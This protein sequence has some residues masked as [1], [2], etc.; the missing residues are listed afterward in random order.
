MNLNLLE[1]LQRLF[2]I[3]E[4]LDEA[5]REIERER[6][7]RQR[8]VDA[9]VSRLERLDAHVSEL[10]ERLARLEAARD[11]DRAQAAAELARFLAEVEHA[12]VR[13]AK[14][15]G[16]LERPPRALPDEGDKG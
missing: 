7:E 3:S 9:A 13:I 6:V 11:A 16:S 2:A 15:L 1:S 10:R 5:A 4:R 8:F 14:R 12:E